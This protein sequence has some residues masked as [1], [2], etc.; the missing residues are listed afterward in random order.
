MKRHRDSVTC[1]ESVSPVELCGL[2]KSPIQLGSWE[3]EPGHLPSLP[4]SALVSFGETKKNSAPS[5]ARSS[6]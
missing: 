1:P 5:S 6:P 4:F 3:T 2:Y